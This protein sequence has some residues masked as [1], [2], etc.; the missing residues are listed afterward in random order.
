MVVQG[1]FRQYWK[2]WLALSLL[3]AVAGGFVLATAVSARRTADAFPQFAARHGYDVIVYSGQPLPQLARLPHVVSAL[4][5]PATF[6]GQLRCASCHT[7]IDTNNMLINEVPP[8]ELPRMV[9][10]LSGRMP[11]QS[12]PDEVL[13]SFTLAKDNGVRVGSVI[14]AQVASVAQLSGGRADRSP[15]MNPALRV[16]GIVAAESEFPS[17]TSVHYD[18]YATTAFAAAVGHRAASQSTYYVRLA[19]GGADLAGFDSRYRSLNVYGAYDL[20]AAAGAVE[21]S[22]R[23]QVIGW[24]VLAGLAALAALAV[25]AQ[26]MARQAATEQADHPVLSALGLR[27]REFVLAALVRALLIGVAGGAGAVLLAVLVSPLTPVGEARIAVPSPDTMS[28]D[29]VVL[30][31]GALVVL[32]AVLAVSVWPAVRHARLLAHRQRSSALAVAASRAAARAGLPVTAVVGIRRALARGQ[33]GQP[34][35]TAILGTVMAVAALC[36]TTVFGASLTHLVSSPELYGA[37]FQAYFAND[38]LPG[39]QAT[40]TGPLLDSLRRDRAISQITLGAFVEVNIN[41]RAVRTVVMTPVR[42]PALLSVVDGNLPRGDRD[43]MLGAATMRTAGA[44][45]G[46]TVRVTISDPAGTPHAASFRTIGRAS[47]N[48]G[49]SGLGNG[50]VMTTSAFVDLQCPPGPGQSACQRAVKQGLATVV[51]VRAAPGAAGDAALARHIAQYRDLTTLPAK[52]TVLVNFGESVNFPLLF[53]VALSLFG[54]ATMVHLL[55]VSVARRRQETGLLKSLGFV[56]RQVAAAVCWQA[57]TV[58]LVGIVVGAPIG[59]A[60]G[61]VLWRV[62]ATNFGVVPVPVVPLLTLTAL[63]AGV[64]AAAN[65]LATVP[66]L[67][68]ARSRPGQLPRAE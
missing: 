42:G 54:A 51:L 6:T 17:G 45:L 10:L 7:P 25:I 1:R 32:A 2:S 40:V 11:D 8:R 53:G 22:I 35:G 9:T 4:P 47:L 21:A 19:R 61:R 29:P 49:A 62:F 24:Y 66:A 34:V 50:A 63:T 36:A 5:V 28:F 3:V 52:P 39:S 38:G 64:L 18:L 68:A 13:A 14:Q 23:P 31:L 27:P 46:D 30:S 41:G 55:L 16:V 59:I 67:T 44:R 33:D 60:A 12:D 48:A 20:D 57:S 58:A 15:V 56:R 26:A 43:I 65:V 37:P